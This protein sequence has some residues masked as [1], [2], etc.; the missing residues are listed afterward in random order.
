MTDPRIDSLA[1][2]LIHH[3]LQLRKG[4]LFILNSGPTAA[5]LVKAVYNEAIQTG[6][7]THVRIG[8]EGLTELFYKH[9]T[10]SQ[11]RY[12]SPLALHEIKTITAQL[13]IISEENTKAL[14]HV[15]PKKMATVSHSH[16]KLSQIFLTRAAKHQLRWCLTLYPT[17]AAAQ[18]AEMSLTDYEDFVYTAAHVTTKNPLRYWRAM[19]RKQEKIKTMLNKK[20]TFHI[21]AKDTDLTLST[22]GRKWISCYGRE[23]FP[24]G[25]IFTGPV[26][27]SADGHIRYSFPISHGGRE[28]HDVALTFSKE[29]S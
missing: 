10:P 7:H 17:N 2:V 19:Q 21:L 1:H 18:D 11:L 9:A 13:T 20:K 4:D 27:T 25:E 24:D 15:D 14:T 28:V 16:Q 23:N 22:A 6:A 29:R 26:E 12:I 8:L 3:S 5:P